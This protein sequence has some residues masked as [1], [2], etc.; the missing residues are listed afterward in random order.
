MELADLDCCSVCFDTREGEEEEE[1]HDCE[2]TKADMFVL[3]VL[4]EVQSGVCPRSE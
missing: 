1:E 4:C 2:C 3:C